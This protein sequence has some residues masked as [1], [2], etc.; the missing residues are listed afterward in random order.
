VPPAA[1]A[2]PEA[3][4]ADEVQRVTIVRTKDGEP[5]RVE[6]KKVMRDGKMTFYSDGEELSEQ[7]FEDKMAALGDRVEGLDERLE[8]LRKEIPE[9][10][11]RRVHVMRERAGERLAL[12]P[13]VRMS[14]DGEGA[15]EESTTPDGKRVIRICER[16]IKGD[17]LFGLRRAREQIARNSD[18]SETARAEVLRSLDQEIARLGASE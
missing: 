17:A 13:I 1:P 2:A 14:C 9:G 18:M 15:T 6:L 10:E 16:R 12:A 11:R 4:D 3:P 8:M 5:T 7:A